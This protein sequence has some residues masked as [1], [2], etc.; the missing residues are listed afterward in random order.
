MAADGSC[1]CAA[2]W[3]GGTLVAHKLSI[4]GS[5]DQD[6]IIIAAMTDD[7]MSLI[8]QLLNV[9]PDKYAE[10]LE[11]YLTYTG[12]MMMRVENFQQIRMLPGVII[13]VG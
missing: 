6:H 4:R 8:R 9:Y 1:N 11:T 12:Q 5:D 7:G 3:Q 10:T 2:G 13:L